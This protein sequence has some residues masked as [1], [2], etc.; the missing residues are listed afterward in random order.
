MLDLYDERATLECDCERVYLTGRKSIA[1]DWAPKLESKLIPAFTLDD[2][3]L[4]RDGFRSIIDITKARRPELAFAS[5][6]RAGYFTQ[7]AAH[8]LPCAVQRRCAARSHPLDQ[9]VSCHQPEHLQVMAWSQ[10]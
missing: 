2:V 7:A 10:V 9:G 3:T 6:R 5:A 4:T 1:A 8:Q